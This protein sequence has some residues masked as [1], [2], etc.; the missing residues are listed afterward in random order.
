MS[1]VNALEAGGE[2]AQIPLQPRTSPR[3]AGTATIL[4]VEDQAAIRRHM[5]SCLEDLR[6]QVMASPDAETALRTSRQHKGRIDLLL[7]NFSMRG[8]SGLELARITAA[9]RPGIKVLYMS[10]YPEEMAWEGQFLEQRPSWLAKPFTKQLLAAGLRKSLGGHRR[11]ILVVVEDPEVRSFLR[12]PLRN[13][14]HQVFEAASLKLA[15]EVLDRN[16][17]DLV[18]GDLARIEQQG[19][20][21]VRKL[22]RF[23][24]AIRILALTGR[25]PA[26]SKDM[27]LVQ[28]NRRAMETD[29]WKARWLRGADATLPKPVSVDLLLTTTARLFQD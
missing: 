17:I 13:H 7:T 14:G 12:A 25:L 5:V 9:E 8:M 10:G 4:L 21:T 22:R 23:Y 20:E 18:I 11:G 15:R 3:S 26:V 19:E 6:Y 24:P 28:R 1:V 27:P 2:A 29:D 16:R